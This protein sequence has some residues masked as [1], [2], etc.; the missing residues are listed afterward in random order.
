MPT[1]YAALT[2][3]LRNCPDDICK[4]TFDEIEEILGFELP[5]VVFRHSST[6]WNNGNQHYAFHWLQSYRVV[7][8]YNMHERYVIFVRNKEKAQQIIEKSGNKGCTSKTSREI[9]KCNTENKEGE[10]FCEQLIG[11]GQTY[12]KDLSVDKHDRYLSWEHCYGFFQKN[13]QNHSPDVLDHMCLH[14]AWYLASWGMLRGGAFLLQ[15]DYLVHMPIVELL[16]SDEYAELYELDVKSMLNNKVTEKIEKLANDI[17]E[18][19]RLETITE[20]LKEGK[21]ATDT[22]VTKILLGTIGC[23]P[24]YDRYFKKGLSLSGIAMQRFSA[25]SLSS[26][27]EYYVKNEKAFEDLRKGA[28]IGCIDYTPM[29][30]LDMCFWQFGYDMGIT[31]KE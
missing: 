21:T 20:E 30:V 6:F 16:T 31:P 15:K 17:T 1:K 11:A 8:Q 25:R 19:Y 7:S 5:E 28:S 29:K 9:F 2:Q 22:L 14:L 3:Y 10:V 27:V 26:L 12:L 18:V 24:A 23:V 13:R 4:L